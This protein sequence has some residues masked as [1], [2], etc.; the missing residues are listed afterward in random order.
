MPQL[1]PPL[2]FTGYTPNDSGPGYYF[3]KPDGGSYLGYGDEAEAM[4]ARIDANRQPDQRTAQLDPTSIMAGSGDMQPQ[5]PPVATDAGGM[6]QGPQMSEAPPVSMPQA[7]PPEPIRQGVTVEPPPQQSPSAPIQPPSGQLPTLQGAG[8]APAGEKPAAPGLVV[9]TMKYVA[10]QRGGVIPVSQSVATEGGVQDPEARKA[11]V[12]NFHAQE[13]AQRNLASVQQEAA[14]AQIAGLQ[15]QQSEA[16]RQHLHAQIEIQNAQA[17]QTLV[18]DEFAKRMN[19]AQHEYDTR[20]KREVDQERIFKGKPG[21]KMQA[22]LAIL[23]GG[24]GAGL[25]KSNVNLGL[26]QVNAN[27]DNDIADQRDEIRRGITSAGNDLSR[28][29]DKYGLD[30][31]DAAAILKLNYARRTE[32]QAA[33]QAAYLGTQQ[34]Q[35][36]LAS[37]APQFQKWQADAAATLQA[38]LNGKIRVVQDARIQ[39]ATRGGVRPLTDDE[40][41]KAYEN[42]AKRA[43]AEY[44]ATHGG[45]AP[46]KAKAEGPGKLGQRMA[47]TEA[48]NESAQED[49]AHYGQI[50]GF[51][52]P[53]GPAGLA[54][55][56][57]RT[58]DARADAIAAKIIA[59]SGENMTEESMHEMKAKLKSSIP[60]VREAALRE[61]TSAAKTVHR[62]FE[63]Q[64]GGVTESNSSGSEE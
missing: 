50:Q 56:A 33:Q 2:P 48:I 6:S 29:R 10:G 16:E 17:Q 3:E 55:E 43:E 41:T 36:Q 15:A 46:P 53:A 28:I 18:K 9:P 13:D 38:N 7:A 20:S 34:A 14:K 45:S 22:T 25:S 12:E 19:I 51:V 37:I 57:R 60:S 27:I 31:D 64:R 39:Q 21:A 47:M 26:Q 4:R 32:A 35:I 40:Q 24:I 42:A 11:M 5:P 62:A 59:G 49:L 23:L 1:A 44:K 52:A 8:G 58:L 63:R 30:T 54:T 61:Y